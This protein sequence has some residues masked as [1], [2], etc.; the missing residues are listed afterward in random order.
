[1]NLGISE[2]DYELP[3]SQ[4]AVKPLQNRATSKCLVFNKSN[5]QI[6]DSVFGEIA[7]HIPEGSLLIRNDSKVIWARLHFENKTGAKIEIFILD[8]TDEKPL[9]FSLQSN[10]SVDLK[11]IVGNAK[12]WKEG[13]ISQ[14]CIIN[15]QEIEVKASWI[16]KDDKKV[17]L[18]WEGDYSFAELL[19]HLGKVPLPPYI[20]REVENTDKENYQT[21]YAENLGSVAAPTAGLHF[22]PNIFEELQQK[23][24]QV[25]DITLHVGAGT[26]MPV[27]TDLIRDHI[28]HSENIMVTPELLETLKSKNNGICLGTTSLRAV[29]SLYWIALALHQNPDLDLANFILP[30]WFPYENQ[31]ILSWAEAMSILEK[32]ANGKN[33]Y[34]R[35][36]LCI[37]PGYK[38][39]W[40]S[41]LITNFHQPKSTLL[42]L[43]SA[44][45][46]EEWKAVYQHA[47]ENEYR[48]LS[49]GDGSFLK[50]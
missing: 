9:S 4:I 38:F 21:T 1:M 8:S 41:G 37:L 15:G 32:Y 3:S 50:W 17:K 40:C 14:I 10:N 45:I 35:T 20:K 30:Q 5:G 43:V 33:Y 31:A 48:F 13:E 24:I 7:N 12:R 2:F 11:V 44:C 22:T 25:Q 29:E 49:Y 16:N 39:K 47:L 26:F 18:T 19:E 6:S 34:T 28:M 42:M 46:G 23:S 36:A 27:K